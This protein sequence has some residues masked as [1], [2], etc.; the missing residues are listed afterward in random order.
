MN[1]PIVLLFAS[2]ASGVPTLRRSYN[3]LT[4]DTTVDTS[5]FPACQGEE[6]ISCVAALVNWDSL[7]NPEEDSIILPTGDELYESVYIQKYGFDNH[8]ALGDQPI[9]F[10]YK[11]KDGAEAVLTYTGDSLYGDIDLGDGGDYL[12]EQHDDV[13]V[14]W[15]QV[16]QNKFMDEEPEEG[17]MERAL[18]SMRM[19]ELV[20]MG[21]ADRAREAVYSVTIYYTAEFKRS[22][23]NVKAFANQV[24][25]ETNAG[26]INSKVPIRIKL[27]CLIQSD[28]PDGLDSSKALTRFG[29]S[30]GRNYNKLRKSADTTILLVKKFS[31]GGTCGRNY[32]NRIS[33]GWTV[34]VVAKSCALGYYSFGHEIGHGLG[35]HHDR[36]TQKGSSSTAYAYG[37]TIKTGQYRSIMA[38]NYKGEKRINYYSNPDVKYKGLPTGTSR[39]N[40]AKV[41]TDQRFAAAKIGNER[42]KCY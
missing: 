6:I 29:T 24:I 39:Y 7:R 36:R 1:L 30:Q 26:Y 17:P 20:A 8:D 25:A 21:E 35:L 10:Q 34:G 16:D 19:D 3:L 14:L 15:I 40:N 28:I 12:I 27:H 37:Y 18:P 41:L 13:Y 23:K 42:M 22:T 32:F 31:D 4:L 5:T 33:D 2:V 9:S 11:N 38:Y